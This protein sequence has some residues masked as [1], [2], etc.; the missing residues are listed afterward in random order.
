MRI[1]YLGLEAFVAIANHGS[2]RKAGG[3][4]NLTQTALT[5]RLKKVESELGTP[6]LNR[7]SRTVS[8]TP[9][10]RDLLPQARRLLKKLGEAYETVRSRA[11]QTLDTL[12]FA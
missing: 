5:H 3:V 7:S 9:S 2:I 11:Q 1:Y 8:L 4:L 6:L 12:S 10:G